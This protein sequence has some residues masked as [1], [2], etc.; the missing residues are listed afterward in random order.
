[1]YRWEEWLASAHCELAFTRDL[2]PGATFPGRTP[3]PEVTV[4]QA[5]VTHVRELVSHT[6]RVRALVPESGQEE[7]YIVGRL[8]AI[9]EGG[10]EVEVARTAIP[11]AV[12]DAMPE[13]PTRCAAC[14]RAIPPGAGATH[15][16]R[17]YHAGSCLREG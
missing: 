11:A 1:M 16:G 7:D 4:L 10:D 17:A 3:Y 2:K 13:D 8:V 14:G 5:A 6:M 15:D 9:L 12:A